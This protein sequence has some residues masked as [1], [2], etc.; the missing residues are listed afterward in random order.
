MRAATRRRMPRRRVDSCKGRIAVEPSIA[1][2]PSIAT[3]GREL[4]TSE[5]D[6]SRLDP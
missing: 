1:A 2:E 4:A 3:K 6:G 5:S